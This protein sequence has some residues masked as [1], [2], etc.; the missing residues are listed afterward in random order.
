[1]NMLISRRNFVAS[2][3]TLALFGGSGWARAQSRTIIRLGYPKAGPLIVARARATLEPRLAA[4]GYSLSWHE[5]SAGPQL[6]EAL[7]AGAIDLGMTGDTPP[8]FAQARGVPLTYVSYEPAAPK[9][10]AFLVRN[11]A[12][13]ATIADLKGKRIALH[14][15]SNIHYLL[16]ELAH[17]A[18]LTLADFKLTFLSPGDARAAFLRGS[19]DAWGIWEP[20]LSATLT[21]GRSRV[22]VDATGI[23]SNHYYYLAGERLAGHDDILALLTDEIAAT[24]EWITNHTAQAAE[25]LYKLT[26]L[27]ADVWARALTNS[28]FGARPLISEPLTEQQLIADRFHEIGLLPRPIRVADAAYFAGS[29]KEG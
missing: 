3:A 26:G 9:S 20:L 14:R 13:F 19:V 5:F 1:M 7:A 25:I 6:L 12:P 17:K 15:G 10:A 24:G 28:A 23:T 27:G 2:A 18:G 16:L 22:L 11:K 4:M 21:D 8:I 29:T